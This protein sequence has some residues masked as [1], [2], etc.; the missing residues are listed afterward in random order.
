MTGLAGTTIILGAVYM[1]VL[2]KKTFFGPVTHAVNEKL[3][4]VKGRE[5]AAL[6]PLVAIVVWL[7]VYPK[8]VLE[9]VD[10]SVKQLV[11]VMYLKSVTP[12]AKA[13]IASVNTIGETK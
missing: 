3:T 13:T 10:K 11:Q 1:L 8:P 9:P 6:V 7:G 5:L 2:Y 12:E 4:D